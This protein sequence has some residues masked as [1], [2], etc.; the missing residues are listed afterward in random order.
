MNIILFGGGL[1]VL[2]IARSLKEKGHTVDVVGTHNEISKRSRYVRQ[3]TDINLETLDVVEFT[4]LAKDKEYAVIIPME[5]DYATW[6]SANKK[7][8]EKSTGIKCAVMDYDIYTLA[9]DKTRFMGFCK[10]HEIPHPK[11]GIINGNYDDL[12]T[13]I[14]FPSLIKPSHSAG[15]RGIKLVNN[16][17][18]LKRFSKEIIAEYGECTLQEYIHSKCI[19]V[20]E[21][22]G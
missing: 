8:V 3:C 7:E 16:V 14:G 5:D 21:E 9:S 18:E 4:A 17:D 13:A 2:S 1:Q 20:T 6:L 10:K 19:K 11:T 15:S 22:N 12:A